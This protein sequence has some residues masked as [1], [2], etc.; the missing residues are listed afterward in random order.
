MSTARGLNMLRLAFEELLVDEAWLLDTDRLEDWLDLFTDDVRYWAPVRANM[1]TGM[2]R[3]DRTHLLTH[4]D[5]GKFTLGL[6]VK[7]LRTGFA[8]AEEPRSRLRHFV[9][10]VRILDAADPSRVQVSSNIM[11]FRSREGRDEHLFVGQRRDWWRREDERW[12][13]QERYIIVDHDV[14]ENITIFF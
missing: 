12:R 14:I 7:R 10:N 1:P 13:I 11:I 6:R 9:S 2:E 4:F 8:H 5:E 3:L